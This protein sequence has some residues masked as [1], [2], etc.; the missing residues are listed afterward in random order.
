MAGGRSE[1]MNRD[2]ALLPFGSTTLLDR[3]VARLGRVCGEVRILCG[4]ERRYEEH[5]ATVVLDAIPGTGPLGGLYSG[6]RSLRHGVG[7]F[8]AVDLPEVPEEFL[9][10]LLE[11]AS[12]WDAVVP[13]HAAGEEPLCA[14]YG[15]TCVEPVR[16]RLEAGQLKMTSFWPDVRVRTVNDAEI[17][18]FG[19]PRRIFRNVNSPSDL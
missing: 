16:R 10:R 14:V 11:L 2:K 9:A 19:D 5:A 3:A 1:R 12:G 7:L 18:V 8:L 4:P 15:R 6:L 13:V 17:E